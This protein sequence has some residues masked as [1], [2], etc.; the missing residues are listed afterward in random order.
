[1]DKDGYLYIEVQ[2][3]MYGLPHAG[4]L[5]Q[6]LLEQ[7]LN[8][9]GY[10]QNKFILG[11]VDDFGIKYLGREHVM[12]LISILKEHYEISEDWKKHKIHR[13]HPQMGLLREEGTHIHAW[14]C[15]GCISPVST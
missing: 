8:K 13:T 12:H 14:V 3:G 15:Q 10:F 7:R 1:M 6:E 2:K 11:L 5:A 4:I 9:H